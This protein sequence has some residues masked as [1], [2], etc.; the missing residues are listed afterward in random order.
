[1]NKYILVYYL[2][3]N[4]LLFFLMAWD[5]NQARL[6]KSRI[7][8]KQLFLWAVLGGGL[9]GLLG[10]RHFRH[11]SKKPLFKGI[12]LGSLLLHLFLNYFYIQG[13]F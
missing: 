5:K 11:K 1:M 2:I 4:L 10:M 8:E 6:G 9:G 13:L 3:I 7:P 12:F